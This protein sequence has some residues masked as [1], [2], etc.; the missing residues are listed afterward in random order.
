MLYILGEYLWIKSVGYILYDKSIKLLF[1]KLQL[2]GLGEHDSKLCVYRGGPT[3]EPPAARATYGCGR[4]TQA[5]IAYDK[6]VPKNYLRN[7]NPLGVI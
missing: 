6:V 7:W 5:E 4:R 1:R 3:A 2:F